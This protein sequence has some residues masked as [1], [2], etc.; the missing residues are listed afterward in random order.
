M[1]AGLFTELGLSAGHVGA[2]KDPPWPHQ[3]PTCRA[4]LPLE[5]YPDVPGPKAAPLPTGR[6]I[7]SLGPATLILNARCMGKTGKRMTLIMLT[8]KDK[9]FA[10]C[11]TR[12]Y[13]DRSNIGSEVA[14]GNNSMT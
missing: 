8:Y 9:N 12:S 7:C 1:I 14:G 6:L 5:F 11:P 10:G 13:M 3:S 2:A 4:C